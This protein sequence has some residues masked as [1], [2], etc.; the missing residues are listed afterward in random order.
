LAGRDVNGNLS[1]IGQH[2]L[3]LQ[4]ERT[5]LT[6]TFSKSNV[7]VEFKIAT[8]DALGK[9]LAEDKGRI[10]HFSCHGDAG[11]LFLEDPAD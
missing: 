5:Q 8:H 7:A 4:D 3:D 6:R 1:P 2:L 10:L 9:Y 11:F